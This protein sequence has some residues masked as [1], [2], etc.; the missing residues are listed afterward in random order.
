MLDVNDFSMLTPNCVCLL[1]LEKAKPRKEPRDKV[2]IG[3]AGCPPKKEEMAL[4]G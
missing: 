4:M 3:L 1:S 2:I